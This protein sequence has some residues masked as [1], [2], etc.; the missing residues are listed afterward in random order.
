[1]K[2]KKKQIKRNNYSK[3][4]SQPYTFI[5]IKNNNQKIQ[6]LNLKKKIN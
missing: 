4:K 1:M 3:Q 2:K 5:K 6:Q